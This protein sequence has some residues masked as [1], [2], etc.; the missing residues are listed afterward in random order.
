MGQNRSN[1]DGGLEYTHNRNKC[2]AVS[3]CYNRCFQVFSCL[4][5]SIV[6]SLALF[7]PAHSQDLEGWYLC[8]THKE[9]S[10]EL[11][12]SVGY[13]NSAIAP[14]SLNQFVV[15]TEE[16]ITPSDTYV[17]WVCNPWDD[18][19]FLISTNLESDGDF[20]AKNTYNVIVPVTPVGVVG[21]DLDC[22]YAMSR[23]SSVNQS[24]SVRGSS[25]V[26]GSMEP[27]SIY[28]M[29]GTETIY[30]ENPGTMINS[31]F[32][33][34]PQRLEWDRVAAFPD[35]LSSTYPTERPYW[36]LYNS[37][38]GSGDRWTIA[39]IA[40][41]LQA[42]R[43]YDYAIEEVISIS[44]PPGGWVPVVAPPTSINWGMSSW[45]TPDPE[46][47]GDI[48]M[49][50]GDTTCLT[51]VPEFSYGP[52]NIFGWTLGIDL[53][54][55]SICASEYVVSLDWLGISFGAWLTALVGIGAIG[56]F[57]S[58]LK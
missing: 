17:N 21:F 37:V 29:S 53:D 40:C 50:E 30:H 55:W 58:R 45:P 16:S 51:L 38:L 4:T 47:V 31:N 34:G 54:E 2:D 1:G 25:G 44:R 57:Y 12:Q 35:Y 19:A 24:I 14:Y 41:S 7:S 3:C 27:V 33:E 46:Q 28:T 13:R 5:V 49:I 36:A 10:F 23:A 22:T 26:W 56:I 9:L 39:E 18:G 42:I 52:W 8:G 48:T 11:G 6:L 15:G 20:G 32:L 43:Y